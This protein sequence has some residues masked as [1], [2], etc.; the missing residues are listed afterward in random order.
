MSTCL[1]AQELNGV[2]SSMSHFMSIAA[3]HTTFML[4][5][6]HSQTVSAK[7]FGSSLAHHAQM[8]TIKKAKSWSSQC[9]RDFIQPMA[10]ASPIS[11][12]IDVC[13]TASPGKLTAFEEELFRNSEMTEIPIIMA[14]SVSQVEGVRTLGMAYCAASTR[15]LG[16]CEFVDDEHFCTLESVIVQLG[17]KEVVIPKVYVAHDTIFWTSN[18]NS[19]LSTLT[20]H[21]W[22]SQW[23]N[24]FLLRLICSFFFV[25]GPA[26]RLIVLYVWLLEQWCSKLYKSKV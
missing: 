9:K 11:S 15:T 7:A 22:I 26:I 23:L 8:Q 16:A 19:T 13:R 21:K 18:N 2:R 4:L 5:S 24:A 25:C 14:I 1:K 10:C 20:P 6:W 17:A 12:K 3:Q